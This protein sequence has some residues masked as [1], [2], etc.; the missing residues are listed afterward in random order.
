[1]NRFMAL[2]L[3]LGVG[4]LGA[5][6]YR[7]DLGEV[8][9]QLQRLG[10]GGCLALF[11]IYFAGF[12]SLAGA[13]LVTLPGVAFRFSWWARCWRVL[14][15]GSALADVTPLAGLG[16][17]PV[18][19]LLLKRDYG[20]P[21]RDAAASLVLARMTDLV[22]Q[23]GFLVVG[24]AL[25]SGTG[26][27]PSF[28]WAAGGGL[29]LFAFAAKTIPFTLLGPLNLVVPVVNFLL[30]WAVYDEPV[31]PA[32]LVGFAFVWL[33]LVVVMWDRLR[34]ARRTRMPRAVA[35]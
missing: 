25:I 33:A 7:T 1:M 8:G 34:E 23:V 2:M 3:A 6:L 24:F 11:A 29:M 19:A 15:V 9:Q 27:A 12:V 18:K 22:A 31:P 35:A 17:E 16:G 30:G 32:R 14:M 4:L 10:W 26:L 28:R 20:I 21:Y 13:W 5:I